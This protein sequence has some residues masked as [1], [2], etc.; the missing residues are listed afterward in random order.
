MDSYN[1]SVK[2]VL[3]LIF[4][5]LSGVIWSVIFHQP[6]VIGFL[7]GFLVLVS[8][9]I[10][11]KM[12][13]KKLLHISLRG[14]NKTRIVIL[15]LFLVSFLLPSWYLSGT[16]DQMVKVALHVII[17][18]HFFVLSF[19]VALS[20]SMLLGTTVGTL[21]AIGVP[22]LGTAIVLHLP[23]DIVAGALVSG[24]FVGDRTSPFSSSHQLLSH[25]VEVPVK[26]Q[27]KAMLLTTVIAIII[28]LCFYGVSDFF[29][30]SKVTI[31]SKP[32]LWSGLSWLKFI[33]PLILIVFVVFRMSII[34]AFLCSILSAAVI[35]FF[36]G[37]SL[38]KIVS[39][40]WNGIN[41]LGGGLVHMYE[42]L[43]FLA[44]AGA[45][46]GLLEEL[47]IIQPYLDKWMQSSRSLVGDTLKTIA[48]TLLISF[49]AA[50]QTLPIILT[51]RSFLPHWSNKYKKEELARVMGDTTMLFPGMVPWSVLAIMCSTIVGIPL[52][53]Y[54]PYAMFLWI[55]PFLTI[56]LSLVKQV[57]KSK[58][59][60]TAA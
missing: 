51:G 28:C 31:N 43:L 1:F 7:P 21:S 8:T 35:A 14:V 9:S 32:L 23:V 22:I 39:S 20:F 13:L 19:I 54:L 49:I 10:M 57:R 24:A 48:A 37:S 34:Y 60:K 18:Q 29:I 45:Y 30:S 47:N 41:G 3:F 50:N 2:Q 52:V 36:D 56:F 26:R 16:I 44:L 46:N 15:I 59:K 25:T 27:W 53:K 33:P 17:P 38:Q 12:P 11:K 4:I 6:L 40:F 5:T 55:L 42:L 58:I